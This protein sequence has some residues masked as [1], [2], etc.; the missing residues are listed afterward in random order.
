LRRI[1]LPAVLLLAALLPSISAAEEG[2]EERPRIFLEKKVFSDTAGGK[3]SFYEPHTVEKG[4][5]LWK[6]LERKSPLTPERYIESLKEFHRANPNVPDP[7][8][9]SPGQKILVPAGGGGKPEEDGRTEAYAVKKGDSLLKILSSRGVPRKERKKH[10]D[11]IRRINPSVRDVNRII[12]GK[13]LRL[14][15][16]AYFEEKAPVVAA[17]GPAQ[18]PERE[19]SPAEPVAPAV[20]TSPSSAPSPAARLTRDVT[21]TPGPDDLAAGKPEA[22]LL[23][24]KAP[25][26]DASLL[27][28][29]KR[30]PATEAVT[31]PATSPYRGLLSDLLN[32]LGEKWVERGTMYLPAPWGGEVV[33]RLEDFPVVRF[34]GGA[35]A[36]V[37]FRGGLPQRVRDAVTANWRQMRVVSLADARTAGEMIDRILRVSGYH[38]IR[39][40]VTRPVII[41]EAVSVAIPARWVVQRTEDS[42]L[43]GD[44]VLVKEVPEKPGEDILA[45]LR[46]AGR[47]GVRVLPYA[48][49]PATAEGFLVGIGEDGNTEGI[50]VALTV[51]REGGLPAVDFGLSVLG[52][53]SKEGERLRIGEKGESFQLVVQPE[54]YFEAGTGKYVVDTG[55]ISPAIRAILTGA[56]YT[57]FPVGKD[58]A[59]RDLFR[60]LLKAAGVAVD[61]RRE[62]LLAGGDK[63]GYEV[64]VTGVFLTLPGAA[65][66]SARKAVLVRGRTHSATRAMLRDLGVE[67]VEW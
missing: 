21:P 14:P 55:K 51:P 5:T 57:V 7:S 25:A 47:V 4:E 63:A 36:L 30:E 40:G 64:R 26:P 31:P 60:R 61:E 59:G 18:A 54:R 2:E 16:E 49:D 24:P 11:A 12:A 48:A 43:S 62:H 35:E 37:D 28:T 3:R 23:V 19:P 52:I 46:Y 39:E 15:T 53:P 27:E 1:I 20:E 6:I 56:G 65:G 34:S 33:L 66:G 50:P 44:L 42:V 45:V 67:I 32:A 10:L 38:S 41:G 8:R 22:E 13:T 29:G 9:L 17:S 58:D